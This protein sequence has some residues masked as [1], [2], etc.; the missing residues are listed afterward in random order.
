MVFRD[1]NEDLMNLF[2]TNGTKSIP[3]LIVLDKKTGN[4]VGDFGPRP[5]GAAL[6]MQKY[7]ATHGLIDE[8]AKTELQLWYFHDKGMGI[9]NDIMTLMQSI[10]SG[11]PQMPQG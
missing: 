4:V 5:Q 3:K 11:L 9:Q 8:K 7:K 1:E 6:F 10:E 2:L